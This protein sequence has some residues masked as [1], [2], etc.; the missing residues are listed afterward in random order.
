M[1][2]F[3]TTTTLQTQMNMKSGG[4]YW[5]CQT[6]P[7]IAPATPERP[8]LSPAA[9]ASSLLDPFFCIFLLLA[10]GRAPRLYLRCDV[11]FACSLVRHL[12]L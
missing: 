10:L 5:T 2:V 6:L 1:T 8:P 4:E 9:T 11:P 12:P 3:Y 7:S